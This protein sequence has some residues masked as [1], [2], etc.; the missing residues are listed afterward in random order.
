MVEEGECGGEEGLVLV[1]AFLLPEHLDSGVRNPGSYHSRRRG[2][3]GHS[4]G[5]EGGHHHVMVGGDEGVLLA[6]DNT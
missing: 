3:V 1:L 4:G 6:T 5:E 2:V